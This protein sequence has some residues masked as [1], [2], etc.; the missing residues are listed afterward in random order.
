M[1]GV[2]AARAQPS[3]PWLDTLL[4]RFVDLLL[5]F[6]ALLLV[7]AVNKAA[8]RPGAWVVIVVLGL[9]SWTGMSRLVRARTLTLQSRDFVEAARALGASASRV[10]LRH[11]LP[12]LLPLVL[13]VAASGFAEMI[14]AESALSFLG[15]GV[16]APTSS[17]GTMLRDGVSLARSTPRLLLL[18]GAAIVAVTVAVNLLSEGLRDARPPRT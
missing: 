12:H 18:P 16:L 7:M 8:A 11:L 1:V 9:L 10:V 2:A 13:V 15:V 17:W 3:R 6:P 5:A 4:M 14:L